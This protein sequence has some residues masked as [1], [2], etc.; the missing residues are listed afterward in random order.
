MAFSNYLAIHSYL[1]SHNG[2]FAFREPVNVKALMNIL[3][4]EDK[5]GDVKS[6]CF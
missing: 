3:F 2:C 1:H 6:S 4:D 5:Y